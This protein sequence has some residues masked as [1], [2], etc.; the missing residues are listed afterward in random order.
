AAQNGPNRHG[1]NN[2]G[3]LSRSATRGAW[4]GASGR[5]CARAAVCLRVA[6]ASTGRPSADFGATEAWAASP[7]LRFSLSAVAVAAASAATSL[8]AEL[9]STIFAA[10]RG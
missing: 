5:L 6:V 8:A 10:A 4:P 9:A 2:D 1:P 3:A 7:S